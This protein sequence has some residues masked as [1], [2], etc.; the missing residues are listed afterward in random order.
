M[1][2]PNNHGTTDEN[3]DRIYDV[4]MFIFLLQIGGAVVTLLLYCPPGGSDH[5]PHSRRDDSVLLS[6]TAFWRGECR[7]K[8]CTFL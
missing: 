4:H 5:L 1:C 8:E 3:Y 2:I 7:C 6:R